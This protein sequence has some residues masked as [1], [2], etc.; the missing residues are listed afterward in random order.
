MLRKLTAFFMI[1][2]LVLSV[3]IP[4]MANTDNSEYFNG[5]D[6]KSFILIESVSETVLSEQKSDEKFKV[7]GLSS[8]A[9]LLLVCEA[10]DSKLIDKDATIKV[11]QEA[12]SFGGVSAFLENGEN[13]KA[14]L[15]LKSAVIICASDAIYALA[16]SLYQNEKAFLDKLNSRLQEL[17]IDAKYESI[18]DSSIAWSAKDLSKIAKALIKSE[19]YRSYSTVFYDSITHEDGRQ[20]ELANPNKLVK[21]L[22]GCVGVG[23]GSSNEAGYC[24]AFAVTR[25]DTTYIAVIIGAQNSSKRFKLASEMMEYVFASY[26]TA[27]IAKSGDVMAENVDVTGG[28]L[29]K[30]NLTAKDDCVLIFEN[31]TNYEAFFEVPETLEAPIEKD[32]VVGKIEYRTNDGK[33]IGTLLLSVQT[34]VEKASFWDEVFKIFRTWLHA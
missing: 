32:A 17:S 15:L 21:Q 5:D 27:N 14:D 25:S 9:P 24:G 30:V 6:A 10:F 12:A 13:I 31:G 19:A 33:V 7:A 26:K 2:A 23:T 29:K 11:S 3:C 4:C 34:G 28:T 1:F 16:E 18:I 20:T 8:L 22:A